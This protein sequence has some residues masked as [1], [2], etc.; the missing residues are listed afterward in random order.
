MAGLKFDITG[1]NSNMLSALQGTQDGVRQT[2]KIIEQSGQSVGQMFDRMS[3]SANDS[4][5][6][7]SKTAEAVSKHSEAVRNDTE[8]QL[9]ANQSVKEL[10][11]SLKMYEKAIKDIQTTLGSVDYDSKIK[12]ATESIARQKETIEWYKNALSNL[13]QGGNADP[14]TVDRYNATIDRAQDKINSL[15]VSIENW[16]STQSRLNS[17]MER[18]TELADAANARINGQSA[19][20]LSVDNSSQKQSLAELDASLTESKLKLQ[21]LEEEAAK[22]YGTPILSDS[23]KGKLSELNAEIAKTKDEI[24]S[25]KKQITENRG[26]TFFGSI[27][28]YIEDFGSKISEAK[29]KVR[30]FISEHTK[31]NEVKDK[32]GS[33]PGIQRFREEYTQAKGV[34]S[35]FGDKITN[36]LTSNGKLQQSFSSMGTAIS[37]MG[38]P[39]K[40]VGAGIVN[41][42]KALWAMCATPIGAIITV[43]VMGLASM[44]KYL[45]KSA[46]GQKTLAQISAFLGSLLSSLTDIVVTIGKFLFHAFADASGP[47]HGFAKGLATTFTSAIKAVGELIGGLGSALKG[48]FNLDWKTFSDGMSKMWN[49]VKDGG[50]TMLS[51][52]DTAFKGAIGSAKLV[53]SMFTDDKFGKEIGAAFDGL[54]SKATTAADLARRTTEATIAAGKAQKKAAELDIQI[55]ENREKIYKLT[56]KAKDALLEETKILQKKRYDAILDA[57]KK[58]LDIQR[59]RNMLH[60]VSLEDLAKERQLSIDVLRT[61]AERAS[62]TRMLTRMQ[63]SN[64]RKMERAAQSLQKKGKSSSDAINAANE[65]FDEISYT[66]ANERE[67]MLLDLENK[68]IDARIA[69]MNDGAERVSAER[70]RQNQKELE[71][72]EKQ[73][74]T[75]LET[76][77]KR[78]KAEFDAEQAIVKARGGKITAWNNNMFDDKNKDVI[79]VNSLFDSLRDEAVKKFIR[80]N[81]D[82]QRK[83][84]NDYLKEYGTFEDK[85]LAITQEY[86]EKISKASSVGEKASLEMKRDKEIENLR[87]EDFKNS[88]DWNGVFSNLQGHTKQ[89]LQGLRDQLQGLFT[90]GNLPIDQMQIISDKINAIDEELGKQQGIWD[91][92]G[93]RAREHNRL[94]KEAADAQERLNVAKE[95]ENKANAEVNALKTDIQS[96]LSKAGV[97]MDVDDIS[98]S[99][100]NGK[101]DLTDE[102]FKKMADILQKLA[103]AEGKLTDA[104]KKTAD[105]TNEAAQKKDAAKRKAAQAVSDWFTDKQK[106]IKDKGIDQMPDLLKSVGLG[107][108]GEKVS[109]GLNAFN[110]AT[111]AAVDFASGNYIGAALKGISAI[112]SF[113]SLLGI[114]NGNE[115]AVAETTERLTKSNGYLKASIDN[116]KDSI[117]KS[118]GSK[119]VESYKEAYKN[120]EAYNKN[121]MDILRAQMGYHGRYHSNARNWRLNGDDYAAINDTLRKYQQE[122]PTAK[123]TRSSVGS[124]ED[125]L[126]LTPEQMKAI[127]TEQVK[128]WQKMLSQGEYDKSE[129]WEKYVELAGKLEELT[130]K[131]NENLTKTTFSSLHDD[132]VSTIMDMDATASDFADNFAEMMAKAW[133][134]AAVGNLMDADLKK[135]YDKWAQKMKNNDGSVADLS[136]DE[137]DELRSEYQGLTNNAL[138]LRDMMM[139]ATGYTGKDKQQN[140]SANG[141]S[142]ITYEQA[143]NIVALTTA[144]NISR[145]QIKE[146]V[147]SVIA[148]ISSITAFSSSTNTAVLEIRNLM[149]Y[150]NSYLEDILK[151]SKAIYS[152]FSRKMDDVNNNLKELR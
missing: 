65:K 56:G 105:A 5:S 118:N 18:Y 136:K 44:Y 110:S 74:K 10:K 97:N 89:Y 62:S 122:N 45:T 96:Q 152:D 32:I 16:R 114:G 7:I 68:L 107:K 47:M 63:E 1:D 37:G 78:Q 100:L 137:I 43:I 101:I 70:K 83:G 36:F 102:K 125:I 123:T 27:R 76:E 72:I 82:E 140:A 148:S 92:I 108:A 129:Y 120:Q 127:S 42:T 66:N 52:I 103:V 40:G 54:I 86:E 106:F 132:F 119:A 21:Q 30:E 84:L 41:V 131:I 147:N 144:G 35:D 73:R 12:K 3:A 139:E 34:V 111:G 28:N 29:E 39:L 145:D 134:N 61:T 6:S 90:S 116:L 99:A 9:L 59:E 75:A 133:T 79:H 87:N 117:D 128:I 64:R 130:G 112:K 142:S 53:H 50:K 149:V 58:Q 124:L 15:A 67:K 49:G 95:E 93:D 31:L 13:S 138:K 22:F 33:N 77:R 46:D 14:L 135:F 143:N 109:Q 151:C 20:G 81:I 8:L 113:G 115:K 4:A 19:P 11:E 98:T 60:T 48:I 126:Q 69:A 85:K 2:Q 55:A 141:V 121:Q 80:E 146:L 51:A 94:L 104:R 150:N 26:N 57:Q 38:L 88:I 71:E 91:Y 23:Q 17:D 24:E 25:L